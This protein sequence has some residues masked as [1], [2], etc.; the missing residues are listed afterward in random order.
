MAPLPR[1]AVD[2]RAL[3]PAATGIGVYTRSLLTALARRGEHSFTG[4]VH[5]PPQE[6]E[7][8]AEL[9]VPVEVQPA[10]L[11]VLWQQWQLRKRL[12]R[13]D[14]DL[15]WS[16]LGILPRRPPVPSIVTV[17]DL[18][19]LLMPEAHSLKV[20]WS[21]LPFLRATLEEAAV[22]VAVSQ[23]TADDLAFHFPQCA[24]RLRVVHN[25]IDPVFRPAAAAA[26]ALTRERLGCRDGY[27]LYA[28][29]IEPRKNLGR[30]LRAWEALADE[31][32][33]ATPPLLLAGPYGWGSRDL[34]A[35]LE[36]LAPRGVRHLG[37][38]PRAELVAAIQAATA[39]V[40]PSLYE[41]FGL[42]PAEA[43]ACGV[44]VVVAASSSLPEVVGEAGLC[45]PPT[46]VGALAGA[47]RN[48][49]DDAALAARLGA[50]GLER[51]RSFSWERAAAG[52]SE[53]FQQALAGP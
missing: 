43:M 29:T 20:R 30:L 13:G 16:P 22:V 8:L 35:R 12:A 44:P 39:F 31:N 17:H 33:A 45:V 3:V 37:R 38:L 14:L 9:G 42:P 51:S 23:A 53:V 4:V 27:L 50:A 5:R 10:P 18:T 49:L 34:M 52:M 40:Y 32:P 21:Q 26:I 15:F 24:G 47:L 7:V 2:L 1:I 25:G 41:G 28:G 36:R 11:G 6:A 48:L 46:D 19:V